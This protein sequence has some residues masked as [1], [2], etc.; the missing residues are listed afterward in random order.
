ME[1]IVGISACFCSGVQL[2]V[3]KTKD[4]LKSKET[5]YCLGSLVHNKEVIKDL[6]KNG[7][8]II[9]SLDEV[10]DD[11]SVIVR[12]HGIPK[13]VYE[14]A[15]RRNIT[16]IDLTCPRVLRIHDLVKKDNNF[17]ILFGEEGHPEVVGT[18]SFCRDGVVVY[19]E[20][21]VRKAI[22]Y[23]KKNKIDS[24][25][26]YTQTTY[27]LEKYNELIEIIK[28]ELGDLDLNINNNI[29][30]VTR[31]RQKETYELARTVDLMIIIGGRNSSNTLKLYDIASSITKT[32]AIETYKDLEDKDL[33][34][35]RIGI[36][37]GSST[38]KSSI[39]ECIEYIQNKRH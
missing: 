9:D 29:C 25:S 16:L 3:D 18:L 28:E 2:S 32:Y 10:E 21:D 1:I 12:A 5:C 19:T 23:I 22:K 27:S 14:E 37:A 26:V 15:E 33:N 35:N 7:L 39:D 20:D 11:S 17:I 24:V 8:V 13:E 36:M 6:E 38:P 31:T 4:L 34:Y 30:A